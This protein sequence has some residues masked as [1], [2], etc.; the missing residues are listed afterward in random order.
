VLREP[1]DV[2]GAVVAVIADPTGAP[3]GVAQVAGTEAQR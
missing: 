2:G 3:V 1:V